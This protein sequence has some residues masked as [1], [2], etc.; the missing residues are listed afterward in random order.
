M[1]KSVY[2]RLFAA[3]KKRV[4]CDCRIE[5]LTR[6]LEHR[7]IPH[8]FQFSKQPALGKTSE[9]FREQWDSA[10]CK[11]SIELVKIVT[12]ESRVILRQ[13]LEDIEVV[14]NEIID[15]HSLRV[16]L[17]AKRD[18]DSAICKLAGVLKQRHA[19]K[20]K[21]FKDTPWIKPLERP[22]PQI[23]DW[24]ETE[25]AQPEYVSPPRRMTRSMTQ[26]NGTGLS[27]PLTDVTRKR[28]RVTYREPMMDAASFIDIAIPAVFNGTAPPTHFPLEDKEAST[29]EAA[30]S[31]NQVPPGTVIETEATPGFIH[32]LN[33]Q[34][35]LSDTEFFNV[36][37]LSSVSL[38]TPQLQ[39]LSKGLNFTP[40]PPSVD[41][42][43]LRESIVKF[44]R[45]LRLVEF[46]HGADNSSYDPKLNKFRAKSSWTPPAN[47][48]KYL[49]TFVGL[50]T[51][52]IMNAP[53]QKAYGNL[54]AEERDALRNLQ[55]D[56]NIVVREAD[57]GSAVVV[58]D[59]ER[60]IKEGN[61][62]LDDDKVYKRVT[63]STINDIELDISRL[64]GH[65]LNVGVITEDMYHHAVREDTKPARFYLLPKV[66][67]RGVPGRPV[68]SA[69]GSATEGLSEIVD[70]FLQP[71]IPA[72]P[73]HIKDTSDFI[74]KINAI[75]SIPAGALLVTIDVVAL[76][77]SI[78]HSDGLR[79]L[80]EFLTE[81]H[82]PTSVVSGICE[83]AELVLK[84]NVFE[85]DSEFFLQTSGTAI[86]TKMAPAYANIFMCIVERAILSSTSHKPDVWLRFI[87]DIFLI[88]THGEDSLKDFISF[89]N[90]FNPNLQFTYEYSSESVH[91]LDV[92][93]STDI[94]GHLATDLYTKP[95]DTHQYLMSNS[96]HPNHTKRSIPYS[97]ALR[98]LRICSNLDTARKRC[99]ELTEF[100]VRRGHGRKMVR[101]QVDRA[102]SNY[103]N[104]PPPKE[105]DIMRPL[106]FTVQFHPALPDIKGIVNKYMPLLHQ[107]NT[108]KTAVPRSP[109]M[110][111]SQPPNLGRSLC[112]AKLRNSQDTTTAPPSSCGKK[113]CKLCPFI[114]CADHIASTSNKRIFK[115]RNQ[116]TDCDSEWIIYAIECP[117]CKMQYV[118]Q[119]N[120]FRL[121]MNGHRSDFKLYA[122]GRSNKMDYKALYDHFISHNIENFNVQ[123]IDRLLVGNHPVEKL[124]DMLNVREKE[125]MWKLDSLVPKGLN[126]DD[127]FYSQNKKGRKTH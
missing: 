28:P 75:G 62:Q 4:R 94:H 35:Q 49:D 55:S 65:L 73:S 25:H 86:G 14:T 74:H 85:F 41:R 107:S 100:L 81:R 72:I 77:P 124:H 79:A 102:I 63:A 40:L 114:Q 89:I 42:L 51:S 108:M 56:Q 47:R 21:K 96:C 34:I 27:Q 105:Q 46:F 117:I 33:E 101:Q 64:A 16:Y 120:S 68:I 125:W 121:R 109:I 32:K 17:N 116:D 37:N 8:G 23:Q 127:C 54:N 69:C 61:R 24:W 118:G 93:I 43:S 111:F 66:H 91:F 12:E 6:C 106:F 2:Y 76:Y 122:S 3:E 18:V 87:D 52:E 45:N 29:D 82:L 31:S 110:S 84:K 10:M 19:S 115:C 5:F 60:Y 95:T 113:R 88:W 92:S 15:Q 97:Q 20:F 119:S 59:R 98:I 53:E 9:P 50:I 22:H 13:C 70:Y 11:T 104:P 1:S 126:S 36:I 90:S 67:K 123:I 26:K 39:L 30:P 58:M 57:K 44:E 38:S 7:V 48:D 103:T 99:E 80:R 83:M 71:Y 112:R 78:P